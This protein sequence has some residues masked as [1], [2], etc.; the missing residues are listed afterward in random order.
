MKAP[1][2]WPARVNSIRM[3][4]PK[5][6]ELLFR[7]V[8]ALPKASRMGLALNI[9]CDRFENWRAPDF[10]MGDS[11]VA[12][13]ARYWMTFFVF[14]VLPAPDSPLYDRSV[15]I[16]QAKKLHPRDQYTLILS[17]I[18]QATKG[19]I[20]HGED[21]WFCFISAS[22]SVHCHVFIGVYWQWA[23]RVNGNKEQS[24]IRLCLIS[25]QS[26]S[27]NLGKHT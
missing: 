9:C 11:E 12:T 5:R 26:D 6:D 22:T 1:A 13:A 25:M 8:C 10:A 2:I 4:F 18:N 27:Q 19:T 15:G 23:V 16:L 3:N 21:M 17:L 20:R 24:G 7:T 14:S